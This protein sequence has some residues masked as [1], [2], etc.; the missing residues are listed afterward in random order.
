MLPIYTTFSFGYG[1]TYALGGQKVGDA[2]SDLSNQVRLDHVGA[3]SRPDVFFGC[4][5]SCRRDLD[6]QR[7]ESAS[8]SKRSGKCA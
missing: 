6:A 2:W 5:A 4:R 8:D 3:I 1:P 7:L